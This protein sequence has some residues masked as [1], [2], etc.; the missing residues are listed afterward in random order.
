M[1]K[2][3]LPH[4]I[5]S[6]AGANAWEPVIGSQFQVYLIPPVGVSNAS[7][8]T[9][10]VKNIQGMFVENG[11]ESSVEQQYQ[12][13]K[14]SYDSNE[15]ETVYN[16]QITFTLNLNDDN[17]NYVYSTIKKW[18]RKRFNP[19]TGERGLKKNY[20]GSI[21]GVKFNRD[22]SIFWE[23]TAHQA[24]V[25]SNIPDLPGDYGSHEPQEI[26]VAFRSDWVTDAN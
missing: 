12:T 1:S 14:R 20:I 21:V 25:N 6:K 2:V 7:I 11:G 18:S 17:D 13:A 4:T 24:Y 15:K 10:H 26:E 8:L 19:M 5:N 16:I 9:E 23:R 22:G 3:N